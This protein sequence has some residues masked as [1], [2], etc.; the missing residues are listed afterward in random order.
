VPCRGLVAV[1]LE[2]GTPLYVPTFSDVPAGD[3]CVLAFLDVN[4]SL[5]LDSG[6]VFWG[7]GPYLPVGVQS[8]ANTPV[9][10]DLN[11]VA[12]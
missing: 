3:W 12:W 2:S 4:G 9:V 5:R 8:D 7:W 6:D 10:L 1:T 11:T